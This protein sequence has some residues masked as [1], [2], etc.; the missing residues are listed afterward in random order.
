MT[1]K[2]S[3]HDGRPGLPGTRLGGGD[4][5]RADPPAD[6]TGAGGVRVGDGQL[7][8]PGMGAWEVRGEAAALLADVRADRRLAQGRLRAGGE[9]EAGA[10]LGGGAQ[11]GARAS[12]AD[13]EGGSGA[14][15]HEAQHL[16]LV[17]V[18]SGEG[19]KSV[20]SGGAERIEAWL[21]GKPIP[22]PPTLSAP[23]TAESSPPTPSPEQREVETYRAIAAAIPDHRPALAQAL[24]SF[25]DKLAERERVAP[26]AEPASDAFPEALA[27]VREALHTLSRESSKVREA[28]RDRHE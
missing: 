5:G 15:V 21:D 14:A 1:D 9:G 3:R 20:Q 17:G 8:V 10:R 12:R 13:P 6:H 28:V 25:A 18:R 26:A 27:E 16:L 24:I 2:Q 4:A 11:G 22:A 7:D 19:G 23:V